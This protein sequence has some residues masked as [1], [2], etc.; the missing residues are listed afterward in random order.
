MAIFVI[1]MA[2][3]YRARQ[4]PRYL[5]FLLLPVLPIVFHGLVFLYRSVFN[6]L[7]IWLV[8]SI[9]FSAALAVYIATLAV[10]LF[11]S[12]IALSAQHS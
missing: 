5:F 1:V 6:I 3:R 12:L 9:G 2:W 7:G 8:L 4:R 11:I 10:T